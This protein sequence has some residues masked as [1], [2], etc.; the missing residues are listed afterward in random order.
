MTLTVL[1]PEE[2]GLAALAERLRAALDVT[3]PEPLPAD[4]PRWDVP[5]LLITPHV[6]GNTAGFAQRAWAV[7]ASQIA[8]CAAGQEPPNLCG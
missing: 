2:E 3:D 6:G 1:V 5:G 8:A 7:A 4:H